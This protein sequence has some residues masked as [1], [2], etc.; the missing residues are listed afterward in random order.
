MVHQLRLFRINSYN[1]GIKT[2]GKQINFLMDSNTEQKFMEFI[3]SDGT[4]V[5]FKAAHSN[6]VNVKSLPEPFS[7]DGWIQV[8][9]YKKQFGE[10]ITRSLNDGTDWID[11]TC[12][13]VIEFTRTVLRETEQSISRGRFWIEMNYWND[14]NKQVIKP[15]AFDEW[16]KQLS[17][18]IKKNLPKTKF[19]IN[20]NTYTEYMSAKMK[21]F[22]ERGFKVI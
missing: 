11:P 19:S 14:Q 20:D 3:L 6:I 21:E 2:L 8:F 1:G 12:S 13:P 22:V 17:N 16:F 10:L 15:K 5:L 18:W 4:D 7:Q 9:L